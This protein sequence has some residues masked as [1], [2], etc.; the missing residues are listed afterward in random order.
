MRPSGG[1]TSGAISRPGYH[2]L[3]GTSVRPQT[4]ANPPPS[5]TAPAVVMA[6]NSAVF[7]AAAQK[8]GSVNSCR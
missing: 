7:L 4:M 8:A 2:R 5:T 3:P 1:S 6:A